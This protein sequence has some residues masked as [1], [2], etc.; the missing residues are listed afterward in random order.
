MTPSAGTVSPALV[1]G[2]STKAPETSSWWARGSARGYRWYRVHILDQPLSDYTRYELWGYQ[3]NQAAGEEIY[4]ADR[5]AHADLQRLREDFWLIDDTIA[6]RMIYDDEG[7]FLRPERA[8]EPD[9]YRE[10]R[11]TAL[12]HAVSLDTYLARRRPRLTA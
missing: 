7:H 9:G 12:R 5:D 2:R 1:F 8:A 10:M 6:V 3:A 4:L 11:E